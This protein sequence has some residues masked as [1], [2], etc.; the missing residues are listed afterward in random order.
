MNYSGTIGLI[1][2]DIDS[3]GL[4]PQRS[5]YA[6]WD[7]TVSPD[8]EV[9]ITSL[10][11]SRVVAAA[12][13]ADNNLLVS[14]WDIDVAGKPLQWTGEGEVSKPNPTSAISNVG[15]TNFGP[16]EVVTA[17]VAAKGHFLVLHRWAVH[18][19]G[20]WLEYAGGDSIPEVYEAAIPPH[21]FLGVIA[22]VQHLD[23]YLKVRTWGALP[24]A[25]RLFEAG[26]CCDCC[27]PGCHPIT[28]LE[29][30]CLSRD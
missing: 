19:D 12:R 23:Y 17:Y 28:T 1:V 6:V 26:D 20:R 4:H 10:P 14:V 7:R 29:S 27:C 2:W 11:D 13:D 24:G 9:A 25:R 18:S 3:S 15:I 16:K 8:S 22:A 5:G 21:S 30:G